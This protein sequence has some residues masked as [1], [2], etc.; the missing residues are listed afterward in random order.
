MLQL[1]RGWELHSILPLWESCLLGVPATCHHYYLLYLLERA[2]EERGLILLFPSCGSR[3]PEGRREGREAIHVPLQSAI[4][5]TYK[6]E[7]LPI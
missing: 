2:E 1:P 6:G 5:I 3:I 4:Y 7:E